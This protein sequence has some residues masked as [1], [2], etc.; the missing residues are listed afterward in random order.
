VGDPLLGVAREKFWPNIG[1]AGV[2]RIDG[3]PGQTKAIKTLQMAA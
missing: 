2:H 3:S 1:I